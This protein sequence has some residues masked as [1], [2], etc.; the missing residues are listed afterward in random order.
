MHTF[1]QKKILSE[2][3]L[4][5][6]VL[7]QKLQNKKI[8][9]TNGCFDII[10]IGH[11]KLLHKAYTLSDLVI[12]AINSDNSASKLKGNSR[13]IINEKERAEIIASIQYV[14]Y[15]TIFDESTPL[16]LIKKIKPDILIKGSDWKKSEIAG[17]EF[18]KS[19]GGKVINNF[20]IPNK[21][22]SN[23]ISK[24]KSMHEK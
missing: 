21:S 7:Q 2:Q 4:I 18:V 24:I 16:N 5:P 8:A 15:V 13:P 3:K 17:S 9:F 14:K 6:K 19:I 11:I 22:S 1:H 12:V 10:H 20:Y 23:I